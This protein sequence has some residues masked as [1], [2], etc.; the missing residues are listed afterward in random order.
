RSLAVVFL[1]APLCAEDAVSSGKGSPGSISSANV[2]GL[3]GAPSTLLSANAAPALSP[4]A[5]EPVEPAM[6]VITRTATP[7][8]SPTAVRTWQWLIVAQHSAAVFDA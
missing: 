4:T 6:P 7:E 8:R 1:A 2:E 3:S 5:P